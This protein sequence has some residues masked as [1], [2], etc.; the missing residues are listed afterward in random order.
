MIR[1]NLLPWREQRRR[2]RKQQFQRQLGL[3]VALALSVVLAVFLVN[4]GRIA[5]QSERNQLL[6]KENALLDSSIREIKQLEQQIASLN[7]R[8]AAVEQLQNGRAYPVCLLDELAHR[9]PQ[10]VVLRSLKQ[11]DGLLLNGVA[12]SNAR[13]SEFLHVLDDRASWFGQP[14]LGEIKSANLGQGR[15][16]KK[17]VEFSIR[18]NRQNADQKSK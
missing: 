6:S 18:L 3:V 9:L 15:D 8:R 10:G 13:V 14:E 17:V 4:A 16:S 2:E 12:Q 5:I 11:S 7:A 1:L